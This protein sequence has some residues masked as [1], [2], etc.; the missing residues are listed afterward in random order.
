MT[1]NDIYNKYTGLASFT[2]DGLITLAEYAMDVNRALLDVTEG[3]MA[4]RHMGADRLVEDGICCG[5]PHLH[6]LADGYMI[7]IE[8]KDVAHAAGLSSAM[9]MFCADIHMGADRLVEDGICCGR[10]HLLQLADGYMIV[11]EGKDV[12]H[13]ADLSSAMIMFCADRYV[14]N[15][16][17]FKYEK[18]MVW[19]V[20]THVFGMLRGEV[21]PDHA[22][23]GQSPLFV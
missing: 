19:F 14:F 15:M 22:A 2:E 6:Q 9:I 12:A 18:N 3:V 16:R 13:A 10:P 11:I 7:V 21:K 4:G 5:R 20:T 17:A 1:G 23:V 8:G